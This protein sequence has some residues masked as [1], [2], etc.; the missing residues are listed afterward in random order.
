MNID[1]IEGEKLDAKEFST[2]LQAV[3]FLSEKRLIIVK[4][5]INNGGA[6]DQKILTES[7]AL[8]EIPDHCV[9]VFTETKQPDKRLAI[10]KKLTKAAKSEEFENLTPVQLTLWILKEVNE[11]KGQIDNDTADF[12]AAYVG[13]N[14]WQLSNEVDK[15]ISASQSEP[16]KKI[17]KDLIEKLVPAS[18]SSSIF[19][20]TDA[21][22]AKNRKDSISIFETLVKSGE[23][24]MM[25]FYMIV[26]HFRI[27][28]QVQ[29]LVSQ[30]ESPDRISKALK[31]HPF[32]ATTTSKQSKN[33]TAEKLKTIHSSL[34]KID[35]GIKTGKIKM[36]TDDQTE[37]LLTIE[38]FIVETC[39]A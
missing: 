31:I 17:T 37:L 8:D 9:V 15:L 6:K 38:K 3:P 35:S 29:A 12:L 23:D 28:T 1:I 5:F 25:T 24:L 26:R 13:P 39:A 34:L 19:K 14:L 11:R 33:F 16:N 10:F 30:K 20:L 32:V 7:K 36:T 2:N 21:I 22:A 4:D 27:L 18:V